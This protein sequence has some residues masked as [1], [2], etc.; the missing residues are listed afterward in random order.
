V[1]RRTAFLPG[2]ISAARGRVSDSAGCSNALGDGREVSRGHTSVLRAGGWR[3][4]VLNEDTGS[5]EGVK[6]RTGR[7]ARP[8]HPPTAMNPT[9]MEGEPD[10]GMGAGQR[11]RGRATCR[12]SARRGGTRSLLRKESLSDRNRRATDP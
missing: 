6:D 7:T 1:R 8:G 2:E 10:M 4:P 12:C 11:K 9:F 3:Q 5:L